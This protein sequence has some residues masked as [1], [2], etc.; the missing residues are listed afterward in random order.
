MKILVAV[1]LV[2]AAFAS[3]ARDNT[4]PQNDKLISTTMKNVWSSS[5]EL[6]SY[7]SLATLIKLDERTQLAGLTWEGS[8]RYAIAAADSLR[9]DLDELSKLKNT[10]SKEQLYDINSLQLVAYGRLEAIANTLAI[11][12]APVL[13]IV[14]SCSGFW[15]CIGFENLCDELG[16][17]HSEQPGGVEMCVSD[18]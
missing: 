10:A 9:A 8:I 6:D 16:G 11:P 1:L 4:D 5:H 2:V 3:Q 14:T 17:E 18:A 12:D 7:L 13:P 15:S